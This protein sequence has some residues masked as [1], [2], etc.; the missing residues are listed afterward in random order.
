VG[1]ALGAPLLAGLVHGS[2][3]KGFADEEAGRHALDN[4]LRAYTMR[5]GVDALV[6]QLR[7]MNDPTVPE[8]GARLRGITQPASIV[9]GERDPWIGVE[10]AERLRDTIP[11][12]TL[13]L[14]ADAR[15]F[16]PEDAPARVAGAIG[17]LLAR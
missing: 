14:I 5:L 1:R 3:L 11:G 15:H 2:L 16:S 9:W 8:L 13:D 12:A 17:K 4:F 6:S 7:A 10:V